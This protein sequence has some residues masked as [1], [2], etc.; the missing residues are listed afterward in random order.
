M[1]QTVSNDI[2]NFTIPRLAQITAESEAVWRK[3]ILNKKIEYIKCGKNVRVAR[4]ELDRWLRARTVAAEQGSR[5]GEPTCATA[6]PAG[7]TLLSCHDLNASPL[8]ETAPGTVE[9]IL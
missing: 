8:E 5:A 2:E 9:V 1:K 3:R 4:T 7:Q 6:E